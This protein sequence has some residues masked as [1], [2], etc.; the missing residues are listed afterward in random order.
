[1]ITA[2]H[3][4]LAPEGPKAEAEAEAA[5][6]KESGKRGRRH[7]RHNTLHTNTP[8]AERAPDP[9]DPGCELMVSLHLCPLLVA[10]GALTMAAVLAL[11][12]TA[13][14]AAVSTALVD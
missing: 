4:P 11:L 7:G 10:A 6:S 13:R 3:T 9:C 1:M 2:L 14:V 8:R 12:A 5:S